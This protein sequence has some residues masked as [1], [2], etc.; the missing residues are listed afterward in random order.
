MFSFGRYVLKL[1]LLWKSFCLTLV[2]EQSDQMAIL[3]F[4]IWPFTTNSPEW[5]NFAKSGFCINKF[6]H[7][8]TTYDMQ[9][10]VLTSRVICNNKPECYISVQNSSTSLKFVYNIEN[11]SNCSALPDQI[12]DMLIESCGL[13]VWTVKTS[14]MDII[15]LMDSQNHYPML[16]SYNLLMKYIGQSTLQENQ[17]F[18]S[19]KENFFR[20]IQECCYLT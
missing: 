4:T 6:Q 11:Q 16:Y 14:V 9:K 1:D 15:F 7:A 18:K 20:F 17:Q 2:R 10:F 5:R 12:N 8:T 19:S 13:F 3:F